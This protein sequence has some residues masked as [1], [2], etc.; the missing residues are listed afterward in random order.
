MGQYPSVMVPRH[1][2][3]LIRGALIS[4][5]NKILMLSIHVRC[6]CHEE[7]LG[8]LAHDEAMKIAAGIVNS[9]PISW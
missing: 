2:D 8:E 4:T 6:V 1:G 3:S 7:G 5:E 9:N